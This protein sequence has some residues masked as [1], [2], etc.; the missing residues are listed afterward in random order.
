MFRSRTGLVWEVKVCVEAVKV[1]VEAL[2]LFLES[3]RKLTEVM[4]MTI[5]GI[6]KLK[7]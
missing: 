7:P 5:N 2:R 1:L 6:G 4:R 3:V